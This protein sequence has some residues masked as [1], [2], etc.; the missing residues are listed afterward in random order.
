MVFE[1]K[2]RIDS[3]GSIQRDLID[4]DF[5]EPYTVANA[6]G[7]FAIGVRSQL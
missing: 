5:G 4:T 2:V 6:T 7:S 1:L 3:K